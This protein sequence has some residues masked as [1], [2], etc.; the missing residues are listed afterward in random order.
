MKATKVLARDVKDE[1][2]ILKEYA[3]ILAFDVKVTPEAIKFAEEE[4]V[5]IF[6]AD[7]IYN[8]FDKFTE[9]VTEC[10]NSRKDSGGNA[11]VFPCALEAIKENVF[12]ARAPIILGVNITAGILKVGTPLC[13]P[14]KDCLKIGVVESIEKD[15]KS[16][17]TAT[18]KDSPVAVRISG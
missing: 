8:L 14:E 11:A 17:T 4:G 10:V 1:S 12:N 7:I 6:T 15:R 13:I 2:Q 9:Y 3:S 5:K 16:V 18:A